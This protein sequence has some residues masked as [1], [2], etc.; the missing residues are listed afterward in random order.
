MGMKLTQLSI[1]EISAFVHRK[2][3][4]QLINIAHLEN[5]RQLTSPMLHHLKPRGQWQKRYAVVMISDSRGEAICM[6]WYLKYAYSERNI[7]IILHADIRRASSSPYSSASRP[8]DAT[9]CHRR[10]AWC[11]S[12]AWACL[13]RGYWLW[14]E[15]RKRASPA[16][17]DH[18]IGIGDS[19]AS[20]KLRL[21]F[22]R[23]K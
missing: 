7:T 10:G 15:V 3:L 9:K 4:L 20:S 18:S 8:H 2:C 19:S 1:S 13:R 21:Y 11:F 12:S 16:N 23:S 22:M 5:S 6:I 14:Q 17:N